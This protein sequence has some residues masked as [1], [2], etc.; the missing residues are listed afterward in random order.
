MYIT[1]TQD[2]VFVHFF[3]RPKKRTKK[4]APVHLGLRPALR[5]SQRPEGAGTRFAQTAHALNPAF[6]A[7][8]GCAERGIFKHAGWVSLR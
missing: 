7:M 4:R 8:L 2:I 6:T 3:A 1:R 5:F